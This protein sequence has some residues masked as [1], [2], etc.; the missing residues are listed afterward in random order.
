MAE[1]MAARKALPEGPQVRTYPASYE[2]RALAGK[3]V[4]IS[5]YASTT[6]TP[7]SMHDCYGAYT[8][9]VRAGAF[10]KTIA[11]KADV[12]FLTNHD[13]LTMART[14]SGS[15][16]LSEDSTGLHVVAT[17][18][19]ARSDVSD[20]IIAIQDGE[21]DEMSFAFQVVRQ[22][23][24]PDYDERALVEL[25]LNRGDVS[26]V[27]Y[28]ANPT[29]SIGMRAFRTRRSADLHQMALDLRAGKTL[30][31]ADLVILAQML[32]LVVAADAATDV[33]P[34]TRSEP[35]PAQDDSIVLDLLRRREQHRRER[36]R[37]RAS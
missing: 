25:N 3:K 28:G 23:W 15:L 36:P 32:D 18:N 13:G 22:A 33:A 2:V 16:V 29:T 34:P 4:E 21:I 5:G 30:P 11:E 14:R 35:E 6:E 20:M 27:N 17:L 12:G 7:Y 1:D 10:T 26:A 24:S 9:V 31:P 19:T 8:E 37:F